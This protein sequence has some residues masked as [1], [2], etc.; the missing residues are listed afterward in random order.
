MPP[1][2]GKGG[3]FSAAGPWVAL[4]RNALA[5]S[6]AVRRPR[7]SLA[8][9]TSPPPPSRRP[10]CF[11]LRRRL[12][13]CLRRRRIPGALRLLYRVPQRL[14]DAAGRAALSCAPCLPPLPPPSPPPPRRHQPSAAR[15]ASMTRNAASASRCSAS[16]W[17]A[18]SSGASR[19]PRTSWPFERCLLSE[20]AHTREEREELETGQAALLCV[21]SVLDARSGPTLI[22]TS[23]SPILGDQNTAHP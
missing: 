16:R 1:L 10:P 14:L 5:A 21:K 13:R 3:L 7:A 17:N 8:P 22:S 19:C 12:R 15:P 2:P 18:A 6:R 11:L 9:P 23:I 4:R 20:H